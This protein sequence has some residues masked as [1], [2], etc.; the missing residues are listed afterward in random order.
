MKYDRTNPNFI[1][2]QLPDDPELWDQAGDLY[3]ESQADWNPFNNYESV[4]QAY[5]SLQDQIQDERDSEVF[6]KKFE[7]L[8]YITLGLIGYNIYKK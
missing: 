7:W 4:Q 6:W 2:P 1:G 8:I 3:D 5:D